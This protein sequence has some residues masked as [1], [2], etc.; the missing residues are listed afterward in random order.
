MAFI[1][2]CAVASAVYIFNDLFDIES[3]RSHPTKKFRP[4]ASGALSAM[5][6][7]WIAIT[8]VSC[9]V[10]FSK[11]LLPTSF[12]VALIGYFL[13]SIAYTF[14]LKQQLAIDV[15]VLAALYLV[16]IYAGGCATGITIS[17]WLST[18]ALFMC[19]SIAL[20]KRYAELIGHVDQDRIIPGR[21]YKASD[22]SILRSFGSASGII[23]VLVL[24]LYIDSTQVRVSYENPSYLWFIC[25]LLLYWIMRLWISANRRQADDPVLFMQRDGASVFVVLC[26]IL[27]LIIA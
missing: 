3:D 26:M 23:A 6:A 8:L 19:I 18:F 9:S 2:F 12:V 7:I 11:V 16:R 25:P 13:F 22:E 1:A 14:L 17:Y 24:A 5:T 20:A 10:I 27:I 4:I 21:G 15:I